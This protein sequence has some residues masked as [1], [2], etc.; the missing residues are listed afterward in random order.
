MVVVVR[1]VARAG[2][3][4]PDQA[5]SDLASPSSFFSFIPKSSFFAAQSKNDESV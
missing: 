4:S 2:L 5:H 3:V 1:V